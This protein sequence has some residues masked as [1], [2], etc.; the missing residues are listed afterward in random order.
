M[1]IGIKLSDRTIGIIG[2]LTTPIFWAVDHLLLGSVVWNAIKANSFLASLATAVLLSLVFWFIIRRINKLHSAKIDVAIEAVKELSDKSKQLEDKALLMANFSKAIFEALSEI[3]MI[4]SFSDHMDMQ[5]Y[6]VKTEKLEEFIL[7][8]I[9]R[10]NSPGVVSNTKAKVLIPNKKKSSL[11][12]KSSVGD[13]ESELR[14]FNLSIDKSVAG[15][16]F[17]LNENRIINNVN[18]E[19]SFG[20]HDLKNHKSIKSIACLPIN[21]ESHVYGVL[22]VTSQTTDAFQPTSVTYLE[23]YTNL[24]VVV[25]RLNE[26]G[27]YLCERALAEKKGGVESVK[28]RYDKII[29]K[30]GTQTA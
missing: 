8:A 6:T 26:M 14:K 24:L 22:C 23:F 7:G 4:L 21:Y 19:S 29:K 9:V 15:D 1:Q 18:T 5:G 16:A 30:D 13:T 28:C 10:T 11:T 2:A 20:V 27:K 25:Y 3:E 12:I 17:R